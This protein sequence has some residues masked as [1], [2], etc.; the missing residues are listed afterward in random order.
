MNFTCRSLFLGYVFKFT[1]FPQFKAYP[2][3]HLAWGRCGLGYGVTDAQLGEEAWTPV[4]IG[5]LGD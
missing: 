3:K 1:C 4:G 5:R 2:Y